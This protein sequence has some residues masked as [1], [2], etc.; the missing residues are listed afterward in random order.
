MPSDWSHAEAVV[1]RPFV[2]ADDFLDAVKFRLHEDQPFDAR[3]SFEASEVDLHRLAPEFQLPLGDGLPD[4]LKGNLDLVI[5]LQDLHLYRSEMVLEMPLSHAPKSFRVP[6]EVAKTFAWRAGVKAIVA[7]MQRKDTKRVAGQPYLRGH[8]VAR[9]SFYVGRN[10]K[11]RAFPVEPWTPKQFEQQGLPGEAV[12]HLALV[13]PDLNQ[14][15]KN[16]ADAFRLGIREDV[17]EALAA[18]EATPGTKAFYAMLQTDVY[19]DLLVLGLTDLDHSEPLE[20]GGVLEALVKR[21][22]RSTKM[23]RAKMTAHA[24]NGPEGRAILR[25]NVQ[26]MLQAKN[27]LVKLRKTGVTA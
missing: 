25:A 20:K 6:V 22:E 7:V 14:R 27:V 3:D 5:R 9:R 16:P 11:S 8:W 1:V 12:Y 23:D 26:A 17:Y 15:F 24:A 13:T 21:L 10:P 2:S 18:S 4:K 19:T